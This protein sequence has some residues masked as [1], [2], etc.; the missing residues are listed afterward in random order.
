MMEM[1]IATAPAA[2]V[3]PQQRSFNRRSESPP[4]SYTRSTNRL[5]IEVGNRSDNAK[6]KKSY[7]WQEILLRLWNLLLIILILVLSY[8]LN[9]YKNKLSKCEVDRFARSLNYGWNV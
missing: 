7:R 4:P 6:A 8:K 1:S 2:P 9:E 5:D 3:N